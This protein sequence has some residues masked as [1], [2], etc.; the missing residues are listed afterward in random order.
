MCPF[1]GWGPPFE[2]NLCFLFPRLSACKNGRRRERGQQGKE[3]DAKKGEDT[4]YTQ[5][6]VD[7][8]WRPRPRQRR[9]EQ[10]REMQ[11]IGRETKRG[12]SMNVFDVP[13]QF[14]LGAGPH[15]FPVP[16]PTPRL[17]AH[18]TPTARRLARASSLLPRPSPPLPPSQPRPACSCLPA[19]PALSTLSTLPAGSRIE[20]Q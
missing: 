7:P 3:R 5:R 14:Q 17:H 4:L 12:W 16:T 2:T 1:R 20:G 18:R 15:L 10:Q 13:V 6:R 8:R 9:P 19:C 11:Q